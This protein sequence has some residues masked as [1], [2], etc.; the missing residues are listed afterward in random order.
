MIYNKY[1]ILTFDFN[2]ITKFKYVSKNIKVIIS[3]I[4]SITF[5]FRKLD[6]KNNK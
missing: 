5:K 2:K 4:C 3:E 1:G 6:L